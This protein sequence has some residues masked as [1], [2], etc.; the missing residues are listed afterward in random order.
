MCNIVKKVACKRYSNTPTFNW[1]KITFIFFCTSHVA[2]SFETGMARMTDLA[3]LAT[4]EFC[5]T[6]DIYL[7]GFEILVDYDYERNNSYMYYHIRDHT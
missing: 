1:M 5:L 4:L 2:R 3:E 6:R 7:L